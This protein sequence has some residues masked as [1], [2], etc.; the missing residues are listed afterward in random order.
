MV[1]QTQVA[2]TVRTDRLRRA[3]RQ[4]GDFMTRPLCAGDDAV[5]LLGVDAAKNSGRGCVGYP[6]IATAVGRCPTNLRSHV[7]AMTSLDQ[8]ILSEKLQLLREFHYS[9]MPHQSSISEQ[10]GQPQQR[11]PLQDSL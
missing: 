6:V 9:E 4:V 7:P 2:E 11:R 1:Q 8:A 5:S 10:Q 3:R